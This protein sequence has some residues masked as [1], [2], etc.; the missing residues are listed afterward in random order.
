ML[1]VRG[2]AHSQACHKAVT[3]PAIA[4]LCFCSRNRRSTYMARLLFA[5]RTLNLAF[6]TASV[7]L[8][9]L[10]QVLV[11]GMFDGYGESTVTWWGYE[12]AGCSIVVLYAVMKAA[13]KG[14]S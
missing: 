11:K 1:L 4:M 7:A 2:A 3:L 13:Q 8:V 12:L 5:S 6:M 10:W 9:V 14:A